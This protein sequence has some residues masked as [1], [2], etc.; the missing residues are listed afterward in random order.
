[1]QPHAER[2]LHRRTVGLQPEPRQ[3]RLPAHVPQPGDRQ[4]AALDPRPELVVL[5]LKHGEHLR[6]IRQTRLA[7][8]LL[9]R[10]HRAGTEIQQCVVDIEKKY[11]RFFHGSPPLFIRGR[12]PVHGV[13]MH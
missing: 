11:I 13:C 7:E 2:I 6:R 1:M 12:M 3:D 10:L 9:H 8:D 4:L 5:H